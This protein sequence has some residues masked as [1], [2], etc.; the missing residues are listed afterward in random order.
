MYVSKFK[1]VVGGLLAA[2]TGKKSALLAK[3]GRFGM[4]AVVAICASLGLGPG[5]AH[6]LSKGFNLINQARSEIALKSIDKVT[7]T[8]RSWES[9]PAVG[10]ILPE[11]SQWHME[12]TIYSDGGVQIGA[13]VLFTVGDLGNTWK[14]QVLMKVSSGS[15]EQQVYCNP[16]RFCA[17]TAAVDNNFVPVIGPQ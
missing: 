17:I 10:D 14:T 5:V 2:I 7:G 4:A 16:A 9:G 15:F 8:A 11:G 12:L 13:E 1:L 3:A 6:A